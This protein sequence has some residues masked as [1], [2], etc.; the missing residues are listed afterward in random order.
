MRSEELTQAIALGESLRP[1]V[2]RLDAALSN[3]PLKDC[4]VT[5]NQTGSRTK[6]ARNG[7]R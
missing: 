7:R 3:D 4:D 5:E 2:L 6:S 1:G